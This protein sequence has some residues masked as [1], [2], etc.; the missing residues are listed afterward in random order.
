MEVEKITVLE[1]K[2]KAK[3]VAILLTNGIVCEFPIE[4]IPAAANTPEKEIVRIV[5]KNIDSKM[6]L[7]L[8]SK[9]AK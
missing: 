3:T 2:D 9:K 6:C 1:K 5:R 4:M 7:K 8:P